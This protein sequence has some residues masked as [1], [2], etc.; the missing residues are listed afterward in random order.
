MYHQ[1]HLIRSSPHQCKLLIPKSNFAFSFFIDL[2]YFFRKSLLDER[3]VALYIKQLLDCI[4]HLHSRNIVHLDINL[5]NI[6]VDNKSHKVKLMGFTHSKCLKPEKYANDVYEKVYH[7]YG[8][9]EFVSPEVVTQSPITLNTDMWSVGVLAYMLLAGKSPFLGRHTKE[10]LQNVSNCSWSFHDDFPSTVSLEAKD[11]INKLFVLDPKERMTV[12]QALNHPW[13]H[14]AAQQ[15]TSAVLNKQSLV[16]LHSRRVWLNQAKQMEPWAK[17]QKISALL[18]DLNNNGLSDTGISSASSNSIASINDSDSNDKDISSSG[19]GRKNQIVPPFKRGRSGSYDEF[20]M[21]QEH[22]YR[23]SSDDDES[24]NP[25]TYLLPVKDPLF[26]VRLREYRRTRFEKVKQIE[27]ILANKHRQRNSISTLNPY[28]N[29][30]VQE[31]YHVDVYGRCIQRGSLSRSLGTS[32]MFTGGPATGSMGPEGTLRASA[33]SQRI[34]E[35]PMSTS[36]LNTSSEV[37]AKPFQHFLDF[38]YDKRNII[39]EGSAPIIREKLKDM[40][41]IVGSIV[42]FRCRIEGNPTPKCFWYHNDRLIIGDDDRFKFAQAEDGVTTLSICR[43]RVSDIGVYRCAARNQFGLTLTKA[44]LTVGDTPD[45]PSRP[46]VAQ[47]SSDQVYLVWEAPSFNGNSDIL[48]YK[49]DYKISGD[50]KWSNALFTIQECCLIRNLQPLTNYRFRVSCINTIGISSYSWASEE[51]TTLAEG[52]SKLTIDHAQAQTLL[53]NQYNLEKRSQQFVL[54]KKLDEELMD[55]SYKRSPDDVFRIQSNHSPNEFYSNES[56]IYELKNT[57]GFVSVWYAKD[58]TNQTKRLIKFSSKINENEIMILRELREQDRL[59]QLIEGFQFEDPH[60]MDKTYGLIYAHAVPI[61]DFISL[62]HKYS[63]ELV[64]KILRQL[65]DAIQWLHLHG[66]VHLNINPL[67]VLNANM[68]QVNVKLSGF[69][70]SLQISDLIRESSRSN[71]IADYKSSILNIHSQLLT[72]I[73][74]TGKRLSIFEHFF[75]FKLRDKF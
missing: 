22:T 52:E 19:T 49:V 53:K 1:M 59:I 26:T 2:K 30:T 41:L 29:K 40:F 28:S 18:D 67:T 60:T 8:Q 51:I 3:K 33:S 31:R 63:E 44:K 6:V 55:V 38:K 25:G 74:F 39:G 34:T 14:F 50:V 9:P 11:F 15:T 65:L 54:V 66:F 5:D 46:V 72:P 73:D 20:S 37:L 48:C 24:L 35:S 42:T 56:R 21:P 69:E 64:V 70:N 58:K 13:I 47:Y 27:T 4:H 16:E 71:L 36:S 68:T 43:A 12:D 57:R 61:I 7:D 23:I 62:K 45:R 75:T 17:L 10:T 32:V